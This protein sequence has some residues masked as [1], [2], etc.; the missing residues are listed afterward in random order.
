LGEAEVPPGK[1]A[2]PAAALHNS[3]QN[4]SF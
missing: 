1:A 4:R 2:A 3:A